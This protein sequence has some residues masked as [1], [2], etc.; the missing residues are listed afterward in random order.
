VVKARLD[1]YVGCVKHA[2][3]IKKLRKNTYLNI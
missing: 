1:E 3:K 2:A